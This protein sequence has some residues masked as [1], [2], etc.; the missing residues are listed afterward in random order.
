MIGDSCVI[1]AFSCVSTSTAFSKLCPFDNIYKIKINCGW[2]ILFGRQI[3]SAVWSTSRLS[4][5][6]VTFHVLHAAARVLTRT[7][8]SDHIILVL[9]TLHWLPIKH[10]I[11]FKIVLITYK[12]YKLGL[13]S[14]INYNN[15]LY[16]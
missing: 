6:A 4:T 16:L 2:Q 7:R 15:K 8:K 1:S 3:T 10:R 11:D 14:I 9:S 13:Y 12:P 5:R